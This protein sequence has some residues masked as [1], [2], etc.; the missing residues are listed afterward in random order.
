MDLLKAAIKQLEENGELPAEY[1]PH[2]L[3]GNYLG[4]MEA[5]IRPDWLII[6]IAIHKDNEIWLTRTGTHS[7][8]F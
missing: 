5:H 3:S 8:L 2:K 4:F 6:W 7:D 1:N